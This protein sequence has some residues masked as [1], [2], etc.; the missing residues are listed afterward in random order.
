MAALRE[1]DPAQA[2][3]QT[4]ALFEQLER[5]LGRVPAMVRV[6]AHSPSI[7]DTYLH[8][9][10]ALEQTTLSA[11]TR[12]LIAVAIAE[13]NGCDYTLSL[14]MALGKRQGVADADLDAA[15]RG[16]AHDRKTT[17]T[18]QFA[19]SLVR[20]KGRV[21]HADIERLH[22]GGCSDE[23]IVD[24]IAAVALNLFRNYFN[25]AVDTD[26]DSPIVKTSQSERVT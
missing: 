14:G 2:T 17:E 5:A 24:I 11:K 12:A 4:K 21:A 19:T 6:M 8:F 13:I 10:H 20:S 18:L 1:V 25:L 3:G 23:E 15:R 7:L 22:R 9:N 16:Q 26:I